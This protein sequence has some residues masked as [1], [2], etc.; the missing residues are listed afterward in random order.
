MLTPRA[1][2]A[3]PYTSVIDTGTTNALPAPISIGYNIA[4]NLDNLNYNLQGSLVKLSGVYF[5]TNAGTVISTNANEYITI[6]NNSGQSF[7]LSF[8][9]LDLNTAG[10]TL[11]TYAS[12]VTGV[13]YGWSTN[14]YYSVAI[15]RFSDIVAAPPPIMLG[16][17]HSGGNLTFNWSDATYGLQ[18]ATNV[19]GPYNNIPGATS[20]F[21][22]NTTSHPTLF[23][24]LYHP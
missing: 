16:V 4:N 15:T 14:S 13:L 12:S 3:L 6:T 20:G 22:T 2:S 11:P 10:Q 7:Q 5:G 23:F 9:D 19:L 17:S 18:S 24:R 1:G 8:F 21:T